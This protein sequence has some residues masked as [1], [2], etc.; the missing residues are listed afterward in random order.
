MSARL[1]IKTAL[2]KCSDWLDARGLPAARLDAE[3]LLGHVLGMERLELYLNWDRPLAEAEKDN[4]R[5]LMRRRA[6]RVPVAYLTGRKE[7]FS[8]ALEVG[9][10]VLIPRPETEEL[11]EAVLELLPEDEPLRLA[12]VGTGSGAIALALAV[13]RPQARIL[14]TD[15]SP[16]ALERARANAGR[17]GLDDRIKFHQTSLLEGLDGPFDAVV[18]NPP[19][20][21]ESERAGL[22]P[23]VA[24]HE[25]PE[26]LF[27]GPRGLD[28]IE[29]LM[30]A[31][32]ARLAPGG[33]LA[34]E[35]GAE[36]GPALRALLE[37]GAE[38][39][40]VEIRP[41]TAGRDRIALA[42]RRD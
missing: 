1:N 21:A 6:D 11:V 24:E 39:H 29:A 37:A 8:L 30:P 25:P 3:L 13:H 9:P 10:G 35:I 2:D 26:A 19:Y 20:I 14:A 33:L 31:A 36:Q 28:V 16:T 17:L 5:A 22:M 23:D 18:S 4:Y 40:R 34:L 42:R 27:A 12:D 7:F 15:I 41:D 38:L 32:A